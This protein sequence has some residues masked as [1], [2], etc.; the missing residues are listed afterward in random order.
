MF[1]EYPV[2]SSSISLLSRVVNRLFEYVFPKKTRTPFLL[3][4]YF[5]VI[6]CVTREFV[7]VVKAKSVK[8]L[9]CARARMLSL[10]VKRDAISLRF[11]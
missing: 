8:L 11:E 3:P 7:K 9:I 4:S 10:E 5:F 6:L 1:F 2:V